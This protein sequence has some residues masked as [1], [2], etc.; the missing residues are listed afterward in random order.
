MAE[1]ERCLRARADAQA[2]SEL[3]PY[4]L[5][6]HGQ[7]SRLSVRHKPET[8]EARQK[9]KEEGVFY[10]PRDVADFM[11][12]NSLQGLEA[13]RRGYTAFDPAC[14]T[15]VFLRSY[16]KAAN[17][18]SSDGAGSLDLATSRIFGADIDSWVVNASAFVLWTECAADIRQRGL[19]PI[20]AWHLLRLNLAHQD[21]LALDPGLRVPTI[22]P[23]LAVRREAVQSLV[24]GVLP[25]VRCLTR[26]PAGN[27]L[28][29]S[30]LFPEIG[31]GADLV[32]GN[33]PYA[34]IGEGR[35]L[36]EL[37]ARFETIRAAPRVTADMYPLFVEQMIRLSSPA[38]HGG[39]MVLPL[40]VGCSTGKQF[41]AL[42]SLIARTAGQW[43]FAFFDREPHAL[44]GED[45]KTRNAI[46]IWTR[47]EAETRSMIASG[48][49]R[50]WRADSRA[51]M[52]ESIAFTPVDT[53]ITRGVPKV[54]GT[55]EAVAFQQAHQITRVLEH[56]VRGFGRATLHETL[57][58]DERTVYVGATAY[59]FLNVMLGAPEW[60]QSAGTLSE[61]PLHALYCASREDA[62]RVYALLV[63][64]FAFWWW[65]V[66]GDGFHVSRGSLWTLPI[67][68]LFGSHSVDGT[69]AQ[70]GEAIWA[71]A[72]R[73]P[74]I[75]VNRGRTSLAY[76]TNS[77]HS[78]RDALDALI[79][80]A[81][82]LDPRFIQSLLTFTSGVTAAKMPE[83]NEGRCESLTAEER[84]SDEYTYS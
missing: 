71:M 26:L 70:L 11:V 46:V 72:Q 80:E 62:A 37:A 40:S 59:N 53:D 25:E 14:G 3:L 15:G 12:R 23:G 42:R 58:G 27:S 76:S 84:T 49:L 77:A 60:E 64:R 30:E 66:N 55:L 41:V 50:K 31:E 34:E 36:L 75:S 22:A 39:A 32:I 35:D 4:V 54:N 18:T 10:T 73:N 69:L 13:R 65:H 38:S 68:R 57:Q 52:L 78:T 56:A 1:V 5:D 29:F 2:Y 33:P 44:F 48:P 74:V 81:L 16:L 63:S 24:G 19:P 9:K 83:W 82:D 47:Q 6:P 21:S 61:H 45:V 67:G 28:P 7:A 79:V 20:C 17:S 43:R 8:I 51:Q